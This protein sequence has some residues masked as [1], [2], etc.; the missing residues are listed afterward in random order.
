MLDALIKGS[1]ETYD[2]SLLTLRMFGRMLTGEVSL[3]N[4][5]GPISIAQYVTKAAE[6]GLSRFLQIL[7]VVS[8]GLGIVNLLPVPVLDGG[9]LLFYFAEAVRGGKPLP[10]SA[11]F[12]GMY[13]GI[14]LLVGLMGL[15][16]YNDLS[17]VF[18]FS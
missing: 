13:V 2:K 6:I 7:A 16:F 3:K 9:H 18:S 15:A 4:L 1:Q 8:I 12:V 10:E 5:S 17:R 11:Q 14:V